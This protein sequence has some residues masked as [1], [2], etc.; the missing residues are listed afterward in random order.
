MY[1]TPNMAQQG[2]ILNT[3]ASLLDEGNLQST[4]NETLY[5]LSVKTL[6]TAHQRVLEG[7]MRGKVVIDY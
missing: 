2:E 3:V 6:E 7:H 1:N 5:G 4:L